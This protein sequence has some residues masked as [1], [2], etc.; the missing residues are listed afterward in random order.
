MDRK[1]YI[2]TFQPRPRAHFRTYTRYYENDAQAEEDAAI[3]MEREHWEG[4][5]ISVEAA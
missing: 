1:P 5:L 3:L 4:R 2:I